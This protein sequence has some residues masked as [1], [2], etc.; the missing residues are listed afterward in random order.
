MT[1]CIT[2]IKFVLQGYER[3]WRVSD[4]EELVGSYSQEMLE[5]VLR[6]H[7][8]STPFTYF[9]KMFPSLSNSVVFQGSSY[10]NSHSNFIP[11]GKVRVP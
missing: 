3:L 11:S 10:L 1:P 5:L 2:Q 6:N 9:P 4:C 8:C 7:Y